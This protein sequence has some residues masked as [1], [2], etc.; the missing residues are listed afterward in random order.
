MKNTSWITDFFQLQNTQINGIKIQLP[1]PL[2]KKRTDH[3]K[4]RPKEAY[5]RR[6]AIEPVIEHIKTEHRLGINFYK[7]VLGDS[8]NKLISAAAFNF[9]RMMNKYKISFMQFFQSIISSIFCL[10]K[11]LRTTIILV[12]SKTSS[13]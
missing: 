2:S 9:K 1:K 11:N 7:G 5:K 13:F 10:H 3:E 4:R 12:F 6:A 8:I